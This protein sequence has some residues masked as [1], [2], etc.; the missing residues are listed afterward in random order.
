VLALLDPPNADIANW[1]TRILPGLTLAAK[2]GKN[3]KV[4]FRVTDAGSKVSGAKV[5]I[6]GDGSKGTGGKGTAKF[7]LAAGRY[8]VSASKAGY[9]P[10]SLKLRVR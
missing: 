2:K 5:K 9:T 3:G 7:T 8:T 10:D 4:T 6:K 1:Q